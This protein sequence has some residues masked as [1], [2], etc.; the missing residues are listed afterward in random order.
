MVDELVQRR[1][2]T[3]QEARLPFLEVA[4][5]EYDV[6]NEGDAASQ[7]RRVVSGNERIAVFLVEVLVED[8]GMTDIAGITERTQDSLSGSPS[9][10]NPVVDVV[11]LLFDDDE[12]R[13]TLEGLDC[14]T[15]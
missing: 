3:Q 7:C 6:L 13:K 2:C 14:G 11:L 12:L 9:V 4:V 15:Y 10:D 5:C 1:D 8:V